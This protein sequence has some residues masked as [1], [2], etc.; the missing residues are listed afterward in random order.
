MA[1]AHSEFAKALYHNVGK[2]LTNEFVHDL[3]VLTSRGV[4]S[5]AAERNQA[6]QAIDSG[7][8]LMAPKSKG[9]ALGDKSKANLVGVHPDLVKVVELA[10]TLSEQDFT[11]YEGLRTRAQ[12]QKYVARGVSRT[13]DSYH[14]VQ[15]DGWGHAVDLVPIIGGVPKWDW[16]GCYLIAWAMDRA[17]TQLGCAHMITWG[18]AWDR[19]LSDFGG[20]RA[21]YEAEVKAYASRHQGKDFLDGPH[22]QWRR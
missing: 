7:T 21:A 10:I 17:A 13:M 9:F 18:G 19:N 14:M 1:M 3:L 4:D 11:V 2:T 12:Q 20:D 15:P 5:E 6:S 16:N 8:T 22:F